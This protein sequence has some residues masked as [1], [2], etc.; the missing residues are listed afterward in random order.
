MSQDRSERSA[1]RAARARSAE[2]G[3]PYVVALRAVREGEE[4]TSTPFATTTRRARIRAVHFD[5]FQR[6]A[7]TALPYEAQLLHAALP[8]MCDDWG[9]VEDEPALIGQ[10]FF[11]GHEQMA[12]ALI[13]LL[14]AGG[15]W[16]RLATRSGS[17]RILRHAAWAQEQ[18][19]THA[20]PHRFGDPSN[21]VMVPEPLSSDREVLHERVR[22]LKIGQRHAYV[23]CEKCGAD[24]WLLEHHLTTRTHGTIDRGPVVASEVEIVPIETQRGS[25]VAILCR[26]CRA[27][28][29]LLTARQAAE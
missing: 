19:S 25:S 17:H 8:T 9:F 22:D 28:S 18:R 26:S 2:T 3:E 5:Q 7:M 12:W 10:W 15:W 20:G 6:P 14:V 16:H 27:K 23:P 4:T 24:G 13:D 29:G 21:Y 11:P 1:Q